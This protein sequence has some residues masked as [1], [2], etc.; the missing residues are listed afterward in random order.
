MSRVQANIS[1]HTNQRGAVLLVALILLLVLTLIG[2]S[3]MESTGME[4][5][6]AN[7]SRER[8]I[9]MQAAEAGLRAAEA[10]IQTTGFSDAE[11]AGTAGGC[12]AG[13][14]NCFAS[15]CSDGGYC[16]NG[17][18]AAN[19]NTCLVTPVA[20]PI[21]EDAVL[22][23]WKTTGRYHA[24]TTGSLQA[25]VKY[26]VEFMC[27]IPGTASQLLTA[28]NAHMLFRITSLATTKSLK[29]RVML[30]STYK[31]KV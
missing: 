17:S 16:F 13:T 1:M 14:Q 25:D 6:M 12:V 21:W 20:V 3:T 26:I 31:L 24:I 28:S 30:Q 22:N 9:A 4:M 8:L 7:Q 10:Y 23:V 29:S 5:K 11:L 27:Y 15:D 18:N 19:I 2:I